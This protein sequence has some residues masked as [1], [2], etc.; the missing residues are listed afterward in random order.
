M[1]K[2]R[3]AQASAISR[4]GLSALLVILA[5]TSVSPLLAGVKATSDYEPKEGDIIVQSL[6]NNQLTHAIV[7][8]TE[9]PWSHCGVVVKRNGKWKVAEAIGPVREVALDRWIKQGKNNRFQVFRLKDEHQHTVTPF[10]AALEPYMGRPYD[11]RYRMDDQNIYCSE[12]IYK[13]YRDATGKE[14]AKPDALGDLNWRPHEDFI[15]HIEKGHLPLDR[16]IITPV[17]LTRSPLV[18]RVY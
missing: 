4:S 13:A 16:K 1:Q 14:L 2:K 18:Q 10:L 9:S 5:I 15:R 7:G 17:A 8:V 11:I 3:S 6:P 12:L